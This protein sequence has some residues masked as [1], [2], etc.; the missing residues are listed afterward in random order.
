MHRGSFPTTI[1]CGVIPT[2]MKPSLNEGVGRIPLEGIGAGRK[3]YLPVDLFSQW[4]YGYDNV[5]RLQ[6]KNTRF[7]HI[8]MYM[9]LKNT[10]L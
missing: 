3:C 1:L 2:E 7:R 8:A 6:K 9:I 10:C 4:I 5:F